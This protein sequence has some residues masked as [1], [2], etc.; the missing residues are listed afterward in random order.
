MQSVSPGKD[1]YLEAGRRRH[2][3]DFGSSL[4]EDYDPEVIVASKQGSF[5]GHTPDHKIPE[6]LEHLRGKVRGQNISMGELSDLQGLAEHGY[7]HPDDMELHEAAG[8]P[9]EDFMRGQDRDPERDPFDPRQF[10]ASRRANYEDMP[11]HNPAI[12]AHDADA[13]WHLDRGNNMAAWALHKEKQHGK[14]LSE[15]TDDDWAI[16]GEPPRRQ[17]VTLLDPRTGNYHRLI[18]PGELDDGEDPG[19]PT[20]RKPPK[21]WARRGDG[22]KWTK[23]PIGS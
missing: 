9:E 21:D 12:G 17:A 20:F 4:S 8:T 3:R 1:D 11:E 15:F 19:H 13:D 18:D 14:P 7:I 23:S 10:G 6:Y 16:A 22:A 2:A 5:L